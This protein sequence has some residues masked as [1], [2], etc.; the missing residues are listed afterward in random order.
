MAAQPPGLP[1]D[2]IWLARASIAAAW[3]EIMSRIQDL[4][5]ADELSAV[6]KSDSDEVSK[7]IERWKAMCEPLA[8]EGSELHVRGRRGVGRRMPV[9]LE[10]AYKVLES[11]NV[12]RRKVGLAPMKLTSYE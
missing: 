1:L 6:L 2:S 8:R 3:D 12:L 4:E 5:E 9:L 11:L 10:E 7:R